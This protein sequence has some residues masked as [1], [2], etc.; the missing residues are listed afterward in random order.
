MDCD[1]ADSV[2]VSVEDASGCG[3]RGQGTGGRAARRVR[4]N[5]LETLAPDDEDGRMPV[6]D[7]TQLAGSAYDRTTHGFQV[8]STE[9]QDERFIAS[10]TTGGTRGTSTCSSTTARFLA[11]VLDIYLPHA[12]HRSIVADLG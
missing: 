1:S 7:W 9:E 10:S 5:C 11:G 6:G 8:V 12:I 3:L 4:R 2:P